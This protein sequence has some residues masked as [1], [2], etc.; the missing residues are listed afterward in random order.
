ME[1][2]VP[3]YLARVK[4]DKHTWSLALAGAGGGA[5]SLSTTAWAEDGDHGPAPGMGRGE[6]ARVWEAFK[7]GRPGT[8]AT[9]REEAAAILA[10]NRE[11]VGKDAAKTCALDPSLGDAHAFA[12]S[13]LPPLLERV[14]T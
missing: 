4:G 14:Q 12:D 1:E 13:A 5:T 3:S 8:P 7:E 9:S 10:G 11:A 2:R 6:A